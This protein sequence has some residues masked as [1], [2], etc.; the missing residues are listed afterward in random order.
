M[1]L[2]ITKYSEAELS[3]PSVIISSIYH[4][5]TD[6]FIVILERNDFSFYTIDGIDH[7]LRSVAVVYLEA[8]HIVVVFLNELNLFDW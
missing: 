7:M 8:S 2:S 6:K 5:H 1:D 4:C 3:R